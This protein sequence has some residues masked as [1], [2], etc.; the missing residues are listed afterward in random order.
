MSGTLF[1]PLPGN[2]RLA[3]ELARQ[4][5][6][7]LGRLETRRFPD[8]E[9]YLR[10]QV[11]PVGRS[12]AVVCSL[13]RPDEKFLPLVFAAATARDLGAS[14]VGLVAPYLAYLRQGKRFQGG[15][16]LTSV[17][18]ARLLSTEFD[19]LT[20]TDPHLHRYAALDEIYAMPNRVGHA[21]PLLSDWIRA[22][23]AA[24][25]VVGPDSESKQWVEA[26]AAGAGAP[27]IVLEK[28][29][30]GDRD[31]EISVPRVEHWPGRTP[32]LVDDVISSGHTMIEA[33]RRIIAG[34]LAAPVCLAVHALFAEDSYRLLKKVASRIATTNTV[35]HESNAIDV[36]GILA[37]VTSLTDT[38]A[39]GIGTKG[40]S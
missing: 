36:S 20:T 27:Y 40:P 38:E 11:D 23:V 9:S 13:D 22:N 30:H 4:L 7:E 19:W 33:C 10:F 26:V 24:P 8:Q 32:V 1:I 29:R 37:E 25:L 21:A 18:F 39:P 2:E 35:P 16:A 31:V 17:H 12:V 15:E 3:T 28:R 6:G 14:R 34:G 5:D